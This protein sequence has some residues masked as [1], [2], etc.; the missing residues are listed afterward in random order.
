MSPNDLLRAGL[1]IAIFFGGVV[2]GR[3]SVW[4]YEHRVDYLTR[5]EADTL[6]IH[7]HYLSPLPTAH[8]EGTPILMLSCSGA[9]LDAIVI[10]TGVAI[11]NEFGASPKVH[12]QIDDQKPMWDRA[13]LAIRDDSKTLAFRSH[14]GIGGTDMLFAKKYVVT[15][16]SYG[17]RVVGMEFDL[18]SDSSAIL[19][20]CGFMKPKQPKS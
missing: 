6:T 10:S 2:Q 7:G 4:T 1:A 17:K 11:D 8:D 3:E 5:R 9:N 19:R 18:P 12:A 14:N 13:V 20:Y 16:E 15:V